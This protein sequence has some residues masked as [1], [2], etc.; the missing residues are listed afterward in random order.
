MQIF[1]FQKG[2]LVNRPPKE[3]PSFPQFWQTQH[4]VDVFNFNYLMTKS[5]TWFSNLHFYNHDIE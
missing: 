2:V 1:I 4:A 3:S 5:H